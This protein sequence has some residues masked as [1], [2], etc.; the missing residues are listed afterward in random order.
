VVHIAHWERKGM[1]TV[2]VGKSESKRLLGQPRHRW[3]N[4][5]KININPLKPS[6]YYIYH[7][8]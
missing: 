3:W 7:P 2:L 4:N 8:L 6:D 1:H 5:I